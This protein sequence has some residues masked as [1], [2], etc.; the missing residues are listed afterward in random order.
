M[1]RKGAQAVLQAE[2]AGP[3]QTCAAAQTA[4]TRQFGAP[5]GSHDHPTTPLSPIM[6]GIVAIPRQV[7][8]TAASLTG[9]AVAGAATSS[10]IR[11]LVTSFAEKA[12]ISESIV[13]VDEVDVPFWAYWLSTAGYNSPAGFKKFAE[14]VKP[15]VAGLEPQ[16][17]TDL[18][19]AFHKVNYF[20]KDL[21]AAVAANI[22]ANFTKYE[23]E[24]LLQVLSAF[25]EFGFYDAT[26]Y[27]DIADSITY[28]NHYLAPVRACPSQ[29]ASAFAAFAK[30]EHERGDLFVALARGFSE[31]SLAKLGAEERKGTVLKALRAFHRFNFWPDA[32][33]ALLHAA[34]GL[35]GSLSADEAKEVEKY[36]KLLEDA[37]GGEFKVFKEGDDVD[38][39]HWYG[40]H[41]QAPTGYS[42]Y[43]FRE[44][45]VPKQYSPASMRPIK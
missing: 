21:F 15:K 33:E 5:A 25:V 29:L 9:K 23:T 13:K 30:Y 27:D 6:P 4:F 7:I 43:V 26:A 37:A 12:I 11:D 41:T 16:Q 39:V 42:L 14:A 32:T 3:Q 31:L 10:T 38:G 1:L 28:C 17:V 22:S 45:L 35:E 2:R 34:K 19:V 20:D 44:A 8:S 24:Q 36:Q 40:H 18:V